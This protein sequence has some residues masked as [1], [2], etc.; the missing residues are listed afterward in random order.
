M[1]SP[2]YITSVVIVIVSILS[3]FKIKISAEELI[4]VA[5]ALVTGIG[6]LIVLIRRYK[7]GDLSPLG[8]R[9]VKK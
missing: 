7:Q 5:A 4:P 3:L 9:K 2:T 8:V 6:G 1:V